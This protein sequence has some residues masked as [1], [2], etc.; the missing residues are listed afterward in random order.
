[1]NIT[2]RII[3]VFIAAIV[4]LAACND[5]EPGPIDDNHEI[6]LVTNINS[7]SPGTG[8]IGLLKNLDTAHFAVTN[9][10]QSTLTPFLVLD[11]DDVYV[12]PNQRGDVLKKYRRNKGLLDEVGSLSLPSA[13]A[14]INMVIESQDKAY[15]S[16]LKLGKIA[17]I[18]PGSMV[19]T[20]YIDLTSYA[21]GDGSPDPAT[22][23]LRDE[24]LYVTC[25]Q[26][27]DGFSSTHPAQVLVIDLA[28]DNSITS[29]TDDRTSFAGAFDDIHAMFFDEK[30]DL[31]VSCVASYGFV[32][33]QKCG[34]LRIK[35]GETRFDPDY[36][37]NVADY[38]IDDVPGNKID[39]LQHIKYHENGILFGAGNIYALASN[40][41]DYVNDRTSGSF[42]LDLYNQEITKLD[43]PYSNGY[44]ASLTKYKDLI[45]WGLSTE[46]GVGIY[47]YDLETEET[48][49]DPIV[50][51]EG[52]PSVIEIFE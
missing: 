35:N 52:D 45:L 44:A 51:T 17:I 15:V 29:I 30:G 26:T 31:Y 16:L 40:P 49:E 47:T 33:G 20:G 41:P 12:L 25:I 8:Y 32:P 46:T 3:L 11:G 14:S 18:D 13:S 1:M 21:I 6:A 36:F 42:M 48:S 9:A 7:T 4:F 5:N 27:S 43:L 23:V 38:Q 39:Y 10:R 34:F 50:T 24:K 37:F 2:N 19:I 28:N 22:M